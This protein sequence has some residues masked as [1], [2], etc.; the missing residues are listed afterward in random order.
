MK[1]R[2]AKCLVLLMYV[3]QI[4]SD[5]LTTATSRCSRNMHE[6]KTLSSYNYNNI[7][8]RMAQT[9]IYFTRHGNREDWGVPDWR[10]TG[11][12]LY[13][14]VILWVWVYVNAYECIRVYVSAYDA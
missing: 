8:V 4:H 1:S 3:R 5:G 13:I 12:L 9:V 10:K 7:I 6:H 2:N 14:L 11:V